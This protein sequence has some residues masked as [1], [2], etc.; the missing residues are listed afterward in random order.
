[1]LVD[2]FSLYHRSH[3]VRTVYC[4]VQTKVLKIIKFVKVRTLRF[5]SQRIVVG[6]FF[7]ILSSLDYVVL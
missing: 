4:K 2:V 5:V 3:E 1:M 7:S 6:D